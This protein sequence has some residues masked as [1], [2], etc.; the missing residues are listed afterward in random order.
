M[1]APAD[2]SL[3]A[4]EAVSGEQGVLPE[5]IYPAIATQM[6]RHRAWRVTRKVRRSV[7]FAASSKLYGRKDLGLSMR[8]TYKTAAG[9]EPLLSDV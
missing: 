7:G 5:T 3:E 9:F 4:A 6:L 2:R 8:L 1:P